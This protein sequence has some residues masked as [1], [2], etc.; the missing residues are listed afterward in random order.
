[1]TELNIRNTFCLKKSAQLLKYYDTSLA[2]KVTFNPKAVNQSYLFISEQLSRY[3]YRDSI[4]ELN[5]R[6]KD[7]FSMKECFILE[8][9]NEDHKVQTYF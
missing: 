9:Q 6:C 5:L 8:L 2:Y 4:L 3:F 7:A 1:M